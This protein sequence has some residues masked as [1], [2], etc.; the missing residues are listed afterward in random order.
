MDISEQE[1]SWNIW[2][3]I[4]FL[5]LWLIFKF[6]NSLPLGKLPPPVLLLEAGR[7]IAFKLPERSPEKI[8]VTPLSYLIMQPYSDWELSGLNKLN[9]LIFLSV[10]TSLLLP[11]NCGTPTMTAPQSLHDLLSSSAIIVF[12]T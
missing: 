8:Q 9:D 2:N 6:Q 1:K 12:K 3:L 4:H 5:I 11:I 7:M 10:V